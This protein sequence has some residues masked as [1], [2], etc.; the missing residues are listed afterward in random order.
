L[1]VA[2]K[3]RSNNLPYSL[4]VAIPVAGVGDA[5][6]NGL[7]FPLPNAAPPMANRFDLDRSPLAHYVV[8][9]VIFYTTYC[10]YEASYPKHSQ[11]IVMTPTPAFIRSHEIADTEIIFHRG[12]HIYR[13]G[14]IVLKEAAPDYRPFCLRRRR[15]PGRLHHHPGTSIRNTVATSSATAP[16]RVIGCKHTVAA[17]LDA[18]AIMARWEKA[19]VDQKDRDCVD[20]DDCLTPAEIREA[21]LGRP[22]T[23]RARKE[24]LRHHARATCLKEIIWWKPQPAGNTRSRSMI[25]EAV[26]A[27]AAAPTT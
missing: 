25:P 26:R 1:L 21:G 15:Q 10:C 12:Q 14:A 17:M 9:V 19:A 6:D 23:L 18:S 27:T 3:D 22:S 16:T 7:S 8:R 5:G 13:H 24:A 20:E 11:R 2:V 4:N